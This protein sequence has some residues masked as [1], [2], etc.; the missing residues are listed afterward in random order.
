MESQAPP[1]HLDPADWPQRC[2][3]FT[4]SEAVREVASVAFIAALAATMLWRCLRGDWPIGHDHPAHLFR[5]WQFG[6]TLRHHWFSPWNWSHQWFTGYPQNVIYPVGGD[7]FVLAIRALSLGTLSLGKAY[8]LAFLIFYFLYGYAVYFFVRHAVESRIAALIAV[9]FLLTDPGSNDIG[10][11]FWLVDLGVWTA[12]LGMVPA[13][14]GIVAAAK[15]L[16]RP[17]ARTAAVLALCVGLALLCHPLHLI[18]F[19]LAMPLLLVSRYLTTA[20]RVPRRAI[21]LLLLAGAIGL[22]IACYWLVPYLVAAPYAAEAGFRGATLE[23]AGDALTGGRL[24]VR[25]NYL[26]AAFGLFGAV[27]LLATRQTLPMFMGLFIF[28]AIAVSTTSFAGLFG[29]KI[30]Q[31]LGKYIIANRLLMLAKPFWYGAAG[32]LI[33]VSWR[34]I[35]PFGKSSEG[36]TPSKGE[37]IRHGVL[38]LVVAILA[39]PLAFYFVGTFIRGEVKRPTIWHSERR[40]LQAR[41]DFIAWCRSNLNQR[42]QFFRIAHG[43]DWNDHDLTDLAVDVPYPFYKIGETPTGHFRYAMSSSTDVALR[44]ANVRFVL[45]RHPLPLRPALQLRQIFGQK[46][47]LYE[48]RN[49]NP[50]PFEINGTGPVDLV[51]FT[52]EEIIL[53]AGAAAQGVLRLNVTYYPKWRA[54]RDGAPTEIVKVAV[55]GV[56]HSALMQVQLRPGTYR[57]RYVKDFSDYIGSVLSIIGIAAS[58]LLFNDRRV[59]DFVKNRWRRSAGGAVAST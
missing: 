32:F 48:F 38:I 46:L 28:A 10:G 40:D 25:M 36:S 42:G 57:F 13:L 5:I 17:T 24:F 41:D 23:N 29:H 58:V 43:F 2:V 56:D 44:A 54:T 52:N 45:A 27:Y 33:V 1:S 31:L 59:S 30:A 50:V 37:W 49:W 26:A 20:A 53:R 6:Q 55:P 22:L 7:L 39:G 35:A 8:G 19:G 21:L 11:W 15:L 51:S 3:A 34:A 18:F 4:R 14:L 16:E 9:V 12:A 47:W